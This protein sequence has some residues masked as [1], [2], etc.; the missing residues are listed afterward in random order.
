M[1]EVIDYIN[2]NWNKTIRE[3]Q[4]GVPF[5]F[6]SPSIDGIYSDF[7][8]WDTYFT[9]MGLL[10]SGN[11]SQVENNIK[12]MAY[13]VNTLGYIPNSNTILTRSQPPLFTRSVYD[14]WK[15]TDDIKVLQKYLPAVIKEHEFWQT[16]RMTEFGLNC[17]KCTTSEEDVMLHYKYL[18]D[19]VK[20]YS[21]DPKTQYRIGKN[22]I[23]IAESGLDFNMRF[24]TDKSR[25]AADEFLH[26]DLNCFLYDAEQKLIEMLLALGKNEEADIY[27]KRSEKRL[28]QI[29]KYF[30]TNDGIYLDYNFTNGSYSKIITA[31]SL[32][33]YALG[34]SKDPVGAKKVLDVLECSYGV[35]VSP[36]RGNDIYYQ[37]DFPTMWGETTILVYWAFKNCGLF[38]DAKR[39]AQKFISVVDN[40]FIKTHKLFEKY[41]ATTGLVS[42]AEYDAPEMMGWTAAAYLYLNHEIN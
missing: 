12:N 39:I 42:N 22:I 18:S 31:V 28:E 25:I 29:H 4:N 36:N 5:P 6:T 33:P 26:L 34:I 2:S 1:K 35:T 41:D 27:I 32:Y 24:I 37:W 38:E 16:K 8:Y 21:D 10:L 19:R 3:P 7:Y 40:N 14:F 23:I 11:V 15:E 13:F 30:I 20:E 17:Y 9:N